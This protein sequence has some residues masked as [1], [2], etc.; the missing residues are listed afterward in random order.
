MS[1]D[2]SDRPELAGVGLTPLLGTIC[3]EL[4]R[5]IRGTFDRKR[6]EE[7]LDPFL[8]DAA[9]VN[10]FVS[11]SEHDSERLSLTVVLYEDNQEVREIATIIS[12]MM[13]RDRIV[14]LRVAVCEPEQEFNL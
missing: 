12:K 7:F 5:S 13:S 8:F 11:V 14:T 9:Q 2:K 3:H 10:G 6:L 4:L 1:Q